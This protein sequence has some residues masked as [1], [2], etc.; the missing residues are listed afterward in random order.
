LDDIS[1]TEENA[2]YQYVLRLKTAVIPKGRGLSFYYNNIIK[3]N[4][5]IDNTLPKF[6]LI[7]KFDSNYKIK[8]LSGGE[9]QSG[10]EE[11]L[12]DD[13][14]RFFD[15]PERINKHSRS[16]EYEIGI[17]LKL[18]SLTQV[19]KFLLFVW[20]VLLKAIDM[21]FKSQTTASSV[22][23]QGELMTVT[24]TSRNAEAW[25]YRDAIHKDLFN[26]VQTCLTPFLSRKE[27]D[28]KVNDF[29]AAGTTEVGNTQIIDN[30]FKKKVMNELAKAGLV[31]AIKDVY[32]EHNETVIKTDSK[33]SLK[34][35]QLKQF[36]NRKIFIDV[37]ELIVSLKWPNKE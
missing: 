9:M 7:E 24:M 2:V 28:E 36:N 19:R 17:N 8:R 4:T 1:V 18:N 10:D 29:L 3:M 32:L 5:V 14:H 21:S 12:L 37:E 33:L 20:N 16:L 34:D 22:S 30:S 25:L 13:G 31:S 23:I 15:D 11:I 6:P 27:I 26:D 35:Y